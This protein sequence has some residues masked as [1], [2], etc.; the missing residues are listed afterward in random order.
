VIL[1]GRRINDGMGAFVAQKLIK[2]LSA[3]DV[4]VKKAKVGILGLTFKE[5]VPDIRNSKVPDIAK[6]LRDFGIEPLIHDPHAHAA[7]VKH[8]YGFELS[9]MDQW[10]DL[11]AVVFAVSHKEYDELGVAG[12]AKFLKPSGIIVDVKSRLDAAKVPPSLSYWC[13]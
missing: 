12:I 9:S 5:N 2:L 11:D 10:R 13:L 4:P 7:E 3:G 8:E 1:A 6:E